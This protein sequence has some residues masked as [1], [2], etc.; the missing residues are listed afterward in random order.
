MTPWSRG[1]GGRADPKAGRERKGMSLS[2][3]S[4]LYSHQGCRKRESSSQGQQ[5]THH[6]KEKALPRGDKGQS[7]GL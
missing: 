1:G 6:T 3:S 2:D 5:A 4:T 7:A